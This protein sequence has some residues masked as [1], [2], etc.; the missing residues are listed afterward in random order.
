MSENFEKLKTKLTETGTVTDDEINTANLT[1]EEKNLAQRRT[2]R[3]TT[4]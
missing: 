2:L 1:D 4:R 3:Q